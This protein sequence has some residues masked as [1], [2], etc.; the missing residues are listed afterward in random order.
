[1]LIP[2]VATIHHKSNHLGFINQFDGSSLNIKIM[3]GRFTV[4][5][6]VT[7]NQL[8]GSKQSVRGFEL[9][10]FQ[11]NATKNVTLRQNARQVH[12]VIILATGNKLNCWLNQKSHILNDYLYILTC[13]YV[14]WPNV[15]VL[16]HRRSTRQ[17]KM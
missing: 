13:M 7:L 11:S 10:V 3:M 9:N 1:M 4:H 8:T 16:T 15:L 2:Q 14:V 6:H 5:K 17:C 12:N